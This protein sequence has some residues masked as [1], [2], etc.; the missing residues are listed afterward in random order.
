M[1]LTATKLSD[2]LGVEI[3]GI[4]LSNPVDDATFAEIHA[5]H[6]AHQV[7]CFRGQAL[8]PE[9]Q[10]AF[11]KR[12]GG[13]EIHISHE[14]LLD[15]YPEVMVLSN[16]KVDGKYIG[17][18]EAGSDWHSDLSYMAE[19]S[20]GTMLHALE[21]PKI[22]GDTEWIDMYAAYDTLPIETRQRID[23]LKGIHTFDRRRNT[24]VRMPDQNKADP[25]KSY[26]R[27]PPDAHHPIVRTHPETG[28]KALF[29]SPRFTIAIAGMDDAEAQPL[30]DQL[31]DH[32]ISDRFTYRHKW[33]PGDMLFW[34][35]RCTLH[36]ACGGVQEP[37]IRHMHRTTLSGDVPY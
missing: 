9:Q 14:Y 13:L 24:R 28:R 4:D 11:T 23:G 30:L 31:F 2:V 27:S 19:P 16:K 33:Q 25:A 5:L 29:V 3:T 21:I 34:D 7:I 18:V 36:L 12:F 26:D 10:I 22:G 15:G 37:E 1:T 8:D 32:A 17:I 20:M 6:L 35:N